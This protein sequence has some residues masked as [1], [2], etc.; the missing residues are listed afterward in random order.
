MDGDVVDGDGTGHTKKP[1]GST[2]DEEVEA[3]P[4]PSLKFIF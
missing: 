3:N 2:G 4:S 1:E